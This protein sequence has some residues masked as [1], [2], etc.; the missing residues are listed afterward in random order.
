MVIIGQLG[1]VFTATMWRGVPRPVTCWI[2]P[3]MPS[4]TY[5]SGLTAT[6]VVPM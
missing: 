2:A 1:S 6:P 4:A 3:E 5:S